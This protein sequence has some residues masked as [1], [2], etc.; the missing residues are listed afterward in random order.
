MTNEARQQRYNSAILR[1]FTQVRIL[2]AMIHSYPQWGD[3]AT[4]EQVY[5]LED[6]NRN[7]AALTALW[8]STNTAGIPA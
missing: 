4:P 1:A 6:L 3:E 5:E 2:D 7:I 8:Q